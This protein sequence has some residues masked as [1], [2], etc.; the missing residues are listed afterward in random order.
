MQKKKKKEEGALCS[1]GWTGTSLPWLQIEKKI[2]DQ[3]VLKKS[4]EEK[5]LRISYLGDNK[6]MSLCKQNST[7]LNKQNRMNVIFNT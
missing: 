2:K 3:Y 1:D 4:S 6:N 7:N 5:V